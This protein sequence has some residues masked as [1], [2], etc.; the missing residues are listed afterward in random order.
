MPVVDEVVPGLDLG[1]A[2]TVAAVVLDESDGRGDLGGEAG[3]AAGVEPVPV[4]VA[5]VPKW[6]GRRVSK[7]RGA[8]FE[9]VEVSERGL[10]LDTVSENPST[11]QF[12]AQENLAALPC[13][14]R[15]TKGVSDGCKR[16]HSSVLTLS[17]SHPC[18]QY[19]VRTRP[20]PGSSSLTDR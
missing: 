11:H 10:V 12:D 6:K 4:P 8:G 17:T 19:P 1:F 3:G 20:Q 5:D 15:V 14:G 13:V 18:Q 7:C 2:G 16:D 9:G